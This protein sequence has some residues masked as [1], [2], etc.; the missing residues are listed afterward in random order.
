MTR[1]FVLKNNI[2]IKY[3]DSDDVASLEYNKETKE[4][5]IRY[6]NEPLLKYNQFTNIESVRFY[7]EGGLNS[8]N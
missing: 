3:I 1:F 2:E 8:L 6:K 4:V 5:N 7:T